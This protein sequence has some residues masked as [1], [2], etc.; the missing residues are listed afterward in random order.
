MIVLRHFGGHLWGI[1]SRSYSNTLRIIAKET[2]G[3]RWEPANRAW[4]GYIDAVSTTHKRCIE[5]GLIIHG[6]LPDETRAPITTPVVALKGLR[7]YQ[8]TG[9][10]FLIAHAEEGALLADD[11]GLGKTSQ[12]LRAARALRARTLV[13]C[14]S[15]V[16]HVW[17]E[18]GPQWW[19]GCKVYMPQGVKSPEPIP[20]GTDIVV[21]H[22]DIV[23]AWVGPLKEWAQFLV[24]DEA[25]Y[26][27]SDKARRSTAIRDIAEATRWR[28]ALTGTPMT[29]RPRD[30]WNLID[31]LSPMRFGKA[32][33]YYR[34]Y[35]DAHKEQVTPEKTVWIYDGRSNLEELQERLGFFM[36]RRT[37][38][39]VRLELPPRTR[40]IVNVDIPKNL[41]IAP[42]MALKSDAA[43]R[44][45]LDLAADGKLPEVARL[46][47]NH[48]NTGN[49]VLLFTHRRVVAEQLKELLVNAD[50]QAETATGDHPIAERKRRIAQRPAVL[51]ATMDAVATGVDLSFYNV[52]VFAELDWVP[53]KLVQCE[54]R[55]HRFGQRRNVLIQYCIARGTGEELI[56][57]TLIRKLDTFEQAIGKLD[58]GLMRSLE[59]AG[60][61]SAVEAIARLYASF[62]TPPTQPTV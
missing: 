4:V 28:A 48:V 59:G 52:V 10:S 56:R 25:H 38:T 41:Q 9:V 50:V 57:D 58:D 19:P 54:G 31:T 33:D 2:P 7:E 39:D 26:L 21:I 5:R 37:K 61:K 20:T 32:F 13:V 12:A 16:R 46:V 60:Q 8:K 36:L 17:E 15:F 44:R 45:A 23:H 34:R 62:N 55:A 14:P 11:L 35:C 43:L 22:Y 18:Q 53:S 24:L 29:S 49:Q 42:A 27:Q 1:T 47:A 30:L 51:V 3:M 40:V 6:A